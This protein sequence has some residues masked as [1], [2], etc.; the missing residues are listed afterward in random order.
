M[1]TTYYALRRPIARMVPSGSIFDLKDA[2]GAFVGV[3]HRDHL[4]IAADR[5]EKVAHRS[6]GTITVYATGPDAIQA[7]SE[8]GELVTLGDLRAG[9]VA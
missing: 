1:S 4:H 3:L 8:Y 5:D 7:V 9:R 6:G 2:G